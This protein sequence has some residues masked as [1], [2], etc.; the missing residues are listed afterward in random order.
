LGKINFPLNIIFIIVY[1]LFYIEDD[2]TSRK[3]FSNLFVGIAFGVGG[4]LA[5]VYLFAAIPLL[6][7]MKGDFALTC[8]LLKRRCIKNSHDNAK[9]DLDTAQDDPVTVYRETALE[10]VHCSQRQQME[11][12]EVCTLFMYS[13]H[14]I[15]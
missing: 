4:I 5:V 1:I 9:D 6:I 7:N 13:V 11:M 10:S 12:V 8:G 15:V 14:H 3:Y 2:L